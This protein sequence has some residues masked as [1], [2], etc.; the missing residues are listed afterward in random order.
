MFGI[1]AIT[2][3]GGTTQIFVTYAPSGDGQN[4]GTGKGMGV[5]DVYDTNGKFLKQ[6]IPADTTNGKLNAPWGLAL[7]PA[8][9]CMPNA[10]GRYW[11]HRSALRS[12]RTRGGRHDRHIDP[13]LPNQLNTALLPGENPVYSGNGPGTDPLSCAQ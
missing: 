7:A 13:P 12:S 10:R 11:P 9:S 2:G 5:V 1:Q 8:A 6:L 3:A 4:N